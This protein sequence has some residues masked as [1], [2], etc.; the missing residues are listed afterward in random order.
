MTNPPQREAAWLHTAHVQDA[1]GKPVAIR[2]SN[3]LIVEGDK[4]W[5]S[6]LQR[7]T[8]CFTVAKDRDRGC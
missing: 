7:K 1:N 6:V 2:L 5:I 4:P 3:I 8:R